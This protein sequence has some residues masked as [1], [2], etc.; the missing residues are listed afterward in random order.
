MFRILGG[1]GWK[2]EA[3]TVG[4]RFPGLKA[5]AGFE[6]VDCRR[7]K[8]LENFVRFKASLSPVCLGVLSPKKLVLHQD[9]LFG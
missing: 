2:A 7:P 5:H 4:S 8:S 9:L 3:P 1:V 6:Q